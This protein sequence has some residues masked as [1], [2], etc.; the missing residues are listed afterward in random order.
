MSVKEEIL[1]AMENIHVTVDALFKLRK[2][3]EGILGH[4]IP[5]LEE[6]IP[7]LEEKEYLWMDEE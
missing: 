2:A 5:T 3:L 6:N 4:D 1:E 7:T